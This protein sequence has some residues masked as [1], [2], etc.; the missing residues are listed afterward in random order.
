MIIVR[1]FFLA[2]IPFFIVL[3]RANCDEPLFADNVESERFAFDQEQLI[4]VAVEV[5]GEKCS[6]VLD[7]GCSYSAV[8]K[9]YV[10]RMGKVLTEQMIGTATSEKRVSFFKAPTLKIGTTAPELIETLTAIQALDLSQIR[11]AFGSGINGIIGMDVLGN[12]ILKISG[13]GK[14]CSFVGVHQD[15]PSQITERIVFEKM[16]PTTPRLRM[17]VS[18]EGFHSMTID[19]GT[20]AVVSLEH[21]LFEKLRQ[22]GRV[23]IE[24]GALVAGLGETIESKRGILDRIEL[25]HFEVRNVRVRSGTQSVIGLGFLERFETEFDFP[26][27]R[28]YFRPSKRFHLPERHNL[29]E[30][31]VAIKNEKLTVVGVRGIAKDAGIQI[32]DIVTQING[33]PASELSISKF[34]VIQTEPDTELNLTLEHADKPYKV[35]LKLKRKADPFPS[36]THGD[37]SA[38]EK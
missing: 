10:E 38:S 14:Y 15:H 22:K 12:R 26:N 4:T 20:N 6:F 13:D 28:A 7:T 2:A 18:D 8:D 33:N 19:T 35:G 3:G 21:R 36:A 11:S 24:G 30:F 9:I 25:G 5:F 17:R 27:R 31:A 34:R 32:N 16:S 37:D 1:H 23:A 29:S